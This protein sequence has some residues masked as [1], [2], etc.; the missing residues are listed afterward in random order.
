MVLTDRQ[1]ADLH[2]GIYEYLRSRPGEAFEKAALALAEADPEASKPKNGSSTASA[3][4]TNSSTSTSTSTSSNRTVTPLL[5][6]KWTAIP[7]LQKKVLELER[8]AAQNAKIHAHRAGSG[9]MLAPG[10]AATGAT[11][12]GARRMLPRLPCQHTL[13]G[14]SLVVTSVALHPVFTVVASGSEDGTIKVRIVAYTVVR[15]A[16]WTWTCLSHILFTFL[17]IFDYLP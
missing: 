6:K 2:A 8:H 13:Q 7:R 3:T 5:E 1:R 11:G 16:G 4:T 17:F 9:G 12:A 15:P 14:H 10:P